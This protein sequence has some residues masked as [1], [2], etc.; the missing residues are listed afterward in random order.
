CW[1]LRR[2]RPHWTEQGQVKIACSHLDANCVG[3][4]LC[5]PMVGHGETLGV[6][7]LEFPTMHFP[8]AEKETHSQL[9]TQRL[10]LTAA[11]QIALSLPNLRLRDSLRDQSFRDPLT[12]LFNRRFMEESLERELQRASRKKHPVSILFID[13]D[14]F[15]KFNDTFG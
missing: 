8:V 14:H 2:G 9:A 4:T 10:A 1:A 11:G 13:L 12:G 6:L 15:K 3:H 7:H 5:L